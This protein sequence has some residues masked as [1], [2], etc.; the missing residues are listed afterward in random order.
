MALASEPIDAKWPRPWGGGGRSGPLALFG[1][2]QRHLDT[3]FMPIVA[4]GSLL[5]MIL[6]PSL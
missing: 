6:A 3:T 1:P 5:A 2:E 4:F